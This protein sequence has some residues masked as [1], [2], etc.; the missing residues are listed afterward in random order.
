MCVVLSRDKL[1]NSRSTFSSL[2]IINLNNFNLILL[3]FYLQLYEIN[4]DPKRKIFLDDLFQFMQKRGKS[5]KYSQKKTHANT[6][7]CHE[8]YAWEILVPFFF[9]I[10]FLAFFVF[11]CCSLLWMNI[12]EWNLRWEKSKQNLR[13]NKLNAISSRRSFAKN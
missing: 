12:C 11:R 9:V 5:I 13:R 6:F 3:F 1:L 2:Q 10:V 4:D 8:K 7:S